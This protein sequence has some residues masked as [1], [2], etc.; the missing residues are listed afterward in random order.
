M[1]ATEY[2]RQ[3]AA[4]LRKNPTMAT[5]DNICER[6]NRL[7]LRE[8]D[9]RDLIRALREI[10][11]DYRPILEFAHAAD[12]VESFMDIIEKKTKPAK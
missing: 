6:I 7:H 9:Y 8:S 3:L 5:V 1:T 12:S 11:G 2:A 10:I 4:E